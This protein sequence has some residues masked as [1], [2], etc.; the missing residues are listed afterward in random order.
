MDRRAGCWGWSGVLP[1]LTQ[2]NPQRQGCNTLPCSPF[3]CITWDWRR[4]GVH[5][6]RIQSRGGYRKA[7]E[8]QCLVSLSPQVWLLSILTCCLPCVLSLHHTLATG[9]LCL[10]QPMLSIP[11]PLTFVL[12]VPLP[13]TPFLRSSSDWSLLHVQEASLPES[14]SLT[15]PFPASYIT[16][17][18]FIGLTALQKILVHHDLCPQKVSSMNSRI[19]DYLSTALSLVPRRVPCTL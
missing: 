11:Q 2:W 10:S 12:A 1:P 3:W 18:V 15:F 13:G 6:S 17:I 8:R 5:G 4:S 14:P 19:L 7:L 9:L 16:C